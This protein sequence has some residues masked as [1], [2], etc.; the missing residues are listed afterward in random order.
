M[1]YGRFGA[2][3]DYLTTFKLPSML[4]LFAAPKSIALTHS[5]RIFEQ[6]ATEAALSRLQ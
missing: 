4:T 6:P 5:K 1:H 2:R 3:S